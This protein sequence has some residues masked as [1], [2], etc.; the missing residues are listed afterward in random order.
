MLTTDTTIQDISRQ[1]ETW[2]VVIAGAG[3]A[4]M[5]AA[6]SLAAAGVERVLLLDAGP[7]VD[8]RRQAG[9]GEDGARPRR[10]DYERGIGGAGLFSDGKLCLSLDVGGHLETALGDDARAA[11]LADLQEAFAHL[12]EDVHPRDLDRADAQAMAQTAE[13]AGLAFKYYPVA[14]IGTDRCHDVVRRLRAVIEAQGTVLRPDTE[15]LD[16]ELDADGITKLVTV[17]DEADRLEYLRAQN[18]V[19][20]LG[21]VGAATEAELCERLGVTLK[22]Q[23][24][25]VGVRF[26]ASAPALDPLFSLTKDP[27]YNLRLPGGDKVKTHCASEEGEV[28]ALSY[29]GLPLAGGHN[30][31]DTRTGRSGFSILWDGLRRDTTPCETAQ[32]IMR[33]AKARAGDRL[34]VQRLADYE[35]ART[36]T[37]ASLAGLPLSCSDVVPGDIREIL[38]ADFF[39]HMEEFLAR[40]AELAPGLADQAVM[41]APAI[42]W[43]M[44]RVEVQNAFMETAVPGVYACGDGSGWSQGIVHAA[45]TGLLAAGGIHGQEVSVGAWVE[46][47]A[48][49]VAAC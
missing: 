10:A 37:A 43:W 49:P 7:D 13:D 30:Y 9:S 46:R 25:Y 31:S 14:H 5:F 22:D 45:A 38:P 19:L 48:G 3:P 12:T 8:A 24:L 39:P 44:R 35:Q 40:M 28:I 32:A 18:V 2:D 21:K 27:K 15:L 26:E 42:E 1:A 20:A 11:L 17:R 34:V 36:S 41:Y 6:L 23:P 33:R 4:G 47:L 16:V 29:S